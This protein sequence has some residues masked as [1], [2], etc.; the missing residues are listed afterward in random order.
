MP[1]PAADLTAHVGPRAWAVWRLVKA[2]FAL[3]VVLSGT[4]MMIYGRGR[5]Q[6]ATELA[7]Q[8]V[9]LYGSGLVALVLAAALLW[10]L[11]A[12]KTSRPGGVRGLWILCLAFLCFSGCLWPALGH[13]APTDVGGIWH[14]PRR[15]P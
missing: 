1:I 3:A 5:W 12:E 15:G 14:T 9:F 4:G 11:F 8:I 6:D 10:D 7:G 13:A 2:V